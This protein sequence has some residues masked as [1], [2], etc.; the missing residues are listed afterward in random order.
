[1]E[2]LGLCS[3][4]IESAATRYR[5]V[6]YVAPLAEKGI[7]LTVNSFL[8]SAE[9]ASFYRSGKT[10]RKAVGML[11]PLVNRLRESFSAGKYDVLLVQR[12]AMMFGPPLF[13]WL[14]RTVGKYPVVLDLDDATYVR[15]LSPTYG[16]LGSALKFFGKTDSLIEW[17]ETVICGNRFIAE[18]VEKKGKPAVIVPTV[19]DTETFCPV[20]KDGN[21][22]P[23]IGWIGT[24]SSFGLLETLFP[25]LRK[26]ARNYDFTLKIVGSG[27]N[28]IEIDG[29]KIE[30]SDWKLVREVEDFQ[31]LDIGLYPI[32]VVG[33]ANQDWLVGKSGFKAIQYMAIGIPFVVSPVGVC[34]EIGIE[35]ETHFAASTQEQW[36][37]SLSNLLESF[38]KR[39]KMGKS[40]RD[41][42]LRHFTVSQ[43]TDKI[44]KVCHGLA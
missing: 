18:Y 21:K 4:P 5:L 30:N 7:N 11:N 33:N 8:N 38:E 15:Y 34:A 20:E 39:G 40:G 29:V 6:Q 32:T 43:Q 17:S 12:E 36:H 19:V 24:H 26:L 10:F 42:A 41:Y 1:M 23:V 14:A 9:Y 2:V 25:V 37:E 16:R 13:E 28:K 27:R 35:N 44:A 31:S 3:Y 22:P